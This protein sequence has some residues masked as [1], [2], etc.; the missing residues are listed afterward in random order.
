MWPF[1]NIVLNDLNQDTSNGCKTRDVWDGKVIMFSPNSYVY[2]IV[3]KVTW[4][5]FPSK[6]NKFLLNK[7]KNSL[8]NK[9]IIQIFF[10]IVL[11]ILNF[12]KF[13]VIIP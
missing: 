13:N 6:T 9:K 2:S 3:F 1:L 8:N 10:C 12:S 5:P 11:Q 4:L 7:N